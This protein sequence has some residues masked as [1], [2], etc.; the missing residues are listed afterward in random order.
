MWKPKIRSKVLKKCTIGK[1]FSSEK[2]NFRFHGWRSVFLQRKHFL[3]VE[4]NTTHVATQHK[5]LL[6]I[7]FAGHNILTTLAIW[8][9]QTVIILGFARII[10][11]LL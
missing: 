3:K 9:F 2:N 6:V 8:R 11:E 7:A 4:P 1:Q 10:F 5:H